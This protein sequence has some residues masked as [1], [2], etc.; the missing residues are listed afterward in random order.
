MELSHG[1]ADSARQKSAAG[2]GNIFNA[3]V[4]GIIG[5]EPSTFASSLQTHWHLC[6]ILFKSK[7]ANSKTR[8]VLGSN[9]CCTDHVSKAQVPAD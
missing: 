9:R 4:K 8:S 5:Y 3:R 1:P 6:V 2:I 7:L